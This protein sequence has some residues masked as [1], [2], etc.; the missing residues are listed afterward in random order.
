MTTRRALLG[1][2]AAALSLL[3]ANGRAARAD[4]SL[5]APYYENV[6]RMT[7]QN[8]PLKVRQLVGSGHSPDEEDEQG[9]TGLLI[10]AINGNMQ[11]AAILIKAGAHLDTKDRLGNTPLHYAVERDH[12]D[13]VELLLDVGA[14][15]DPQNRNGMT[16]LMTAASRGYTPLVQTLLAKGANPR[17]ADY[18]GRDAASWAQDGHR[19][20]IAQA[21]QRAL[22]KR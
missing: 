10:A 18:T 7:T 19:P 5:F 15:V 22:A 4:L 13:M 1:G 8:D 16:P 6:A 21:L 14:A 17:L 11:I 20:A 12:P 3:L 9:R 2:S